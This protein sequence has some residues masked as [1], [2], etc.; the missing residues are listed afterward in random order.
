MVNWINIFISFL[1]HV[2]DQKEEHEIY[3]TVIPIAMGFVPRKEYETVL[4]HIVLNTVVPVH[5]PLPP[6]DQYLVFVP[7]VM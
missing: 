1:I 5:D 7:M 3:G 2:R 4:V 6:Q